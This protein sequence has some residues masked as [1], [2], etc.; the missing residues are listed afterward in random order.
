M[1][2]LVPSDL[3][4]PLVSLLDKVTE[5]FAAKG[6]VEIY[7]FQSQRKRLEARTVVL[8]FE[9]GFLRSA[10]DGMT[11]LLISDHVVRN[12]NLARGQ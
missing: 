4:H 6:S 11:K 12:R 5:S 10:E 2:G 8:A 7:S 9:N 1:G 3:S